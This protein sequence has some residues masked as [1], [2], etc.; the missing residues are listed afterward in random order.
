MAAGDIEIRPATAAD[1]EA[2]HALECA[3]F[4]APWRLEFFA[5]ELLQ[6]G[7]ICLVAVRGQTLIGYVFAMT[8][9]DEMHVNKIA[10]AASER[11]RGIAE[12]LMQQCFE[13]AD[14]HGIVSI[15]LEVRLSNEGAQAFYE[16][17]GFQRS[18]V[19]PR[20]YP[21]GEAAAVMTKALSS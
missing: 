5:G 3:A 1:L 7:R 9:F 8:I 10:V 6:P 15:S 11:R 4:P 2:V 17:L 12:A 19:R 20:Y 21:D 16:Y 18:Y 14:A 13:Y